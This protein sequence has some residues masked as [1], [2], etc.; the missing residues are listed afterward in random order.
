MESADLGALA[1]IVRAVRPTLI[2]RHMGRAVQ[3][4][5]LALVQQHDP[6]LSEAAHGISQV[7]PYA[8]SGLLRIGTTQAI[9]GHVL[10]EDRAWIRLVGLRAEIVSALDAFVQRNPATIELDHKLWY[11]EDVAWNPAKHPWAGRTTYAHLAAAHQQAAPPDELW[12][13][14]MTP[15]AFSSADLNIPLPDPVRIFD[16]L[17]Q[18]WRA[19]NTLPPGW[20]LPD[21][22]TEFVRYF[23]PLT[24]YR[25][26]T[27]PLEMKSPEIGFCSDGVKF[28]VKRS[29]SVS[30]SMRNNNPDKAALLDQL[31]TQRDELAHALGLLADFAFYSGVGIKTTT[32][33]GMVKVR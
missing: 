19:L 17:C 14:F 16:S 6:A 24:E 18:R 11:V 29:V 20:D 28:S 9:L 7:K 21:L 5:C 2:A 22:L 4:L 30:P 26:S 27:A 25:A 1:I 12:F 31:N 33:M 15:T 8:V 23:V 13:R 10:P 3:Q 32:G